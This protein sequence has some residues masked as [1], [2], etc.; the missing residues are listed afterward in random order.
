MEASNTPI[1][2]AATTFC[3]PTGFAFSDEIQRELK[4]IRHDL[5]NELAGSGAGRNP[6]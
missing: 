6:I 1:S 2:T 4:K 3:L 5:H